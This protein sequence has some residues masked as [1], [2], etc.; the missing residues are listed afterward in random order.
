MKKYKVTMD[1]G[2]K[3]E[4]EL[5]DDVTLDDLKNG[6]MRQADY[7]RKRQEETDKLKTIEADLVK[8]KEAAEAYRTRSQEWDAWWNNEGSKLQNRETE[9]NQTG[10][11]EEGLIDDSVKKYVAD[12]LLQARQEFDGYI[13]PMQENVQKTQRWVKYMD[14]MN[15][16]YH[17]RH[18][19]KF[20]DEPFKWDELQKIAF[21]NKNPNLSFE[22]WE[23]YHDTA[24]REKLLEIETEKRL[25][26]REAAEEES[27]KAAN[28]DMS[29]GSPF[30]GRLF[31]LPDEVPGS[32]SEASEGALDILQEERAK[33]GE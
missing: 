33:R 8:A 6:G 25:K 5:P 27:K 12:A 32:M 11:S 14:D 18:V 24:Y 28:V 17:T 26:E 10:F 22:D 20:K 15:R 4:L 23:R 13:R 2:Q 1:D 21:E 9:N 7:T 3:M 19:T 31:S 16:L 30:A 29:T